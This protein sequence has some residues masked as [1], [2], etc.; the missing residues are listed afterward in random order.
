MNEYDAMIPSLRG[1]EGLTPE[2]C[3]VL[4]RCYQEHTESDI[5]AA[6]AGLNSLEGRYCYD[7]LSHAFGGVL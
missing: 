2:M 4:I 6:Y 3:Y 7:E 5:F 1:I